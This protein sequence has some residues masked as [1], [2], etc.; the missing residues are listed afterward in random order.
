M[1]NYFKSY[2][3]LILFSGLIIILDQYTKNLVRSHIELWTG[4]W[5]P[6]DWLTPYAR[7]VHIPNNGVAF[8]M[9][10]NNGYLFTG[11]I[12]LV[13]LLLLFYYSKIPNSDHFQRIA[14]IFYIGGAIGNLIDRLTIGYVTDFISIG[15]FAVFN[16]ADASINVAVG[17]FVLG[18]IIGIREEKKLKTEKNEL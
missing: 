11:L 14:L 13:V 16:I 12:F 4:V 3:V 9:F 7:A 2:S 6:W 17:I 15:N 8:G 1:K 18:I 10:Q 5:A